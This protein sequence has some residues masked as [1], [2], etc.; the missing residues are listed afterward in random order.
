MASSTLLP[1]SAGVPS[2]LPSDSE[3]RL[4][5]ADLLACIVLFVAM[6]WTL[7]LRFDDGVVP[8]D[9]GTL[10]HAAERV[11]L[12]EWPHRDFDDPYIGLLS[13][14]NAAA[15]YTFGVNL[16]SIRFVLFPVTL[17]GFLLIYWMVRRAMPPA[18]A[19]LV[20]ATAFAWSVPNYFSAM[21]TWYNL[22][23]TLFGTAA[24]LLYADTKLRRWIMLAGFLTGVSFLF[25]SVG[26]YFTATAAL[27]VIFIEQ[28]RSEVGGPAK[29]ASSPNVSRL[30]IAGLALYV[31][32]VAA[33][34][35]SHPRVPEI[36][37]FLAPS[38]VLASYL[39]W[40]ERRLR[41]HDAVGRFRRLVS[42]G[43]SFFVGAAVPIVLFV[44][45]YIFTG[46]FGSWFRGVFITP[47]RRL[48][49][50][51]LG[52]VLAD[53]P[54]AAGAVMLVIVCCVL[55][56]TSRSA[57]AYIGCAVLAA[58]GLL[59]LFNGGEPSV[60]AAVWTAVRLVPLACAAI[61]CYRLVHQ[62]TPSK[63]T[64]VESAVPWDLAF[65]LTAAAG[66]FSLVQFPIA[67]GIYFLYVAPLVI[68]SSAIVL[69][70]LFPRTQAPVVVCGLIVLGFSATW[71]W[72]GHPFMFGSS[73]MP[74]S[75]TT[76]V[77][78][79]RAQVRYD[80][81]AAKYF[82][83]VIEEVTKRTPAG[84]PILAFPDSPD[85]Y[86][87]TGRTNPTRTFFDVFDS[88]YG[89]PERDSRLLELMDRSGVQLVVLRNLAAVSP[90]GISVRLREEIRRRFPNVV[91]IEDRG[92]KYFTVRWRD[93]VPAP[94]PVAPTVE[95]KE[96]KAVK[97]AALKPPR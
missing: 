64:A 28:R 89:T 23:C 70:V 81:E 16:I 35:A 42:A 95:T 61:V 14:L 88:D 49:D 5:P 92:I 46:S 59:L 9:S 77:D 39:A 45:P 55:I 93:K 58:A 68:A 47:Y 31:A 44:L 3:T 62:T 26:L 82:S 4:R 80:A 30:I 13:F 50:E 86:F 19:A 36:M 72:S 97:L 84:A 71:I 1:R 63:R 12:G 11:L 27:F 90:A 20:T 25:K 34:V 37:T 24:M 66:V 17:A 52:T 60:Y 67:H 73:Y 8:H 22:Y 6:S 10:G 2:A 18:T 43:T 40:N 87:M 69:A 74:A 51:T 94:A 56:A 38:A 85:I 21:P 83:A 54:F 15:L 7:M 53:A 41:F 29:I 96:A 76:A 32:A 57:K 91:Y 79:D 48:S 65:L 33:I 78:A 75:R